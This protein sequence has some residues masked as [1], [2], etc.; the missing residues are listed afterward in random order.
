MNNGEEFQSYSDYLMGS[1]RFV[2][3]PK[4]IIVDNNLSESERRLWM[5][6]ACFQYQAD[7]EIFPSRYKLA[8]LMGIENVNSISRIS[9]SLEKKGYLLK[10]YPRDGGVHYYLY[11][12]QKVKETTYLGKF[13]IFK[14]MP[15]ADDTY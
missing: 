13:K 2:R 14:D 3:V 8:K 15:N 7:S 9:K 5:I 1:P 12:R 10:L 6:L 11:L 4:K